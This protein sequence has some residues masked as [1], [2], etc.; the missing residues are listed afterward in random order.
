MNDHLNINKKQIEII[1]NN[2]KSGDSEKI[3]SKIIINNQIN[4]KYNNQNGIKDGN[5]KYITPIP[6]YKN[7]LDNYDIIQY[8]NIIM[9][10]IKFDNINEYNLEDYKKTFN[11]FLKKIK[12]DNDY[13]FTQNF[14]NSISKLSDNKQCKNNKNE[15]LIIDNKIK[16]QS[17]SILS[18]EKNIINNNSNISDNEA[19]NN[20]FSL[21]NNK[22]Y[23]ADT[24][25]NN[26]SNILDNE[27]NNIYSPGNNKSN[28]ADS[29][30]NDDSIFEVNKIYDISSEINIQKEFDITK[31]SNYKR[32]IFNIKL[33]DM[34]NNLIHKKR[35]RIPIKNEVTH[36]H[37][38]LDDD[39]ILRK[40]Q[41]HFL[42]FLVSFT[43]DYIDAI[44]PNIDKN[45]ILHFK[46]IDYKY[47]K[48]INHESIE[49]IKTL[50]IGEILQ[51]EISQKY[52]TCNKKINQIIYNNICQ[53]YPDLKK[54][55]FN[56]LFKEFFIEYYYNKNDGFIFI[57]GIKVNLSIKTRTFNTLIQKNIQ[58]SQKFRE[59]ATY[60]YLNNINGNE[61][62][63][64]RNDDDNMENQKAIKKKTFF[65]IE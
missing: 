40:I 54:K 47:K 9:T 43:N 64:N 5:I 62:V 31:K 6:A 30:L 36:V 8:K 16:K 23:M 57:N 59:I 52:K 41:V 60:F 19:N 44:F 55:Y 37:S 28:M 10:R 48:T 45:K 17:F 14:I 12:N 22:N 29:I 20:T 26:N 58:N 33:Y 18:K 34:N 1:N 2:I 63:I 49:K 3:S 39:N 4:Q 25:I 15:T 65:L 11:D 56:L 21:G 50:T 7:L 51:L 24:I 42:S 35:G 32:G 27:V 61:N 53:L 13:Y 38:A 46:H